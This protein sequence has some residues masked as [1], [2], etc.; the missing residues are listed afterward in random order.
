MT[1]AGGVKTAPHGFST[2]SEPTRSYNYSDRLPGVR[3]VIDGIE[4]SGWV[5]SVNRE[6]V[7]GTRLAR[8][9]QN[10]R[11]PVNVPTVKKG[12]KTRVMA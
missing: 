8:T 1:P 6:T 4:R 2:V 12:L 3:S 5:R 9:R 10:A 7:N 11:L